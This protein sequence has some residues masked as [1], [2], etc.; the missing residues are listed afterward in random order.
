MKIIKNYVCEIAY[1]LYLLIFILYYYV[2]Q[3]THQMV[4]QALISLYFLIVFNTI[5][6]LKRLKNIE[7]ELKQNEI[8]NNKA[9]GRSSI[10]G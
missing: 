9:A 8:S 4:F 5:L 7:T 10:K 1:S 2:V 6:V 3:D